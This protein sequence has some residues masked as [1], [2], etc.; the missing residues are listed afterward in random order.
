MPGGAGRFG[1]GGM[2]GGQF[3]FASYG[4]KTEAISLAVYAAGFFILLGLVYRLYKRKLAG[5]SAPLPSKWTILLLLGT[6]LLLRIAIAPWLPGFVGDMNDF[7]NWALEATQGLKTFYANSGSDYP[8]FLIY[9][10]YLI[11]KAATL[12]GMSTFFSTLIKLPSILADVATAYLLYRLAAKW[13]PWLGFLLAAFYVCNPAILINSTFWGQVDSLFTLLIVLIMVCIAEGKTDVAAALLAAAILMKPQGTIFAPVLFFEWIHKRQFK[14]ALTGILIF[15]GTFL[16]IAFPFAIG[17]K[18]LWLV[19]LYRQTIGEYP[20]AS[21]NGYNFFSLIGANLKEKSSPFLLLS[22][23]TWGMLFIVL[24]TLFTWIIYIRGRNAKY[25]ALAALFQIAGVFTFSS[26]MHER[27][28]F[29]AAA[30]AVCA[31]AYLKD[32]RLMWLAVVFSFTGFANTFAVFYGA[33]GRTGSLTN[34]LTM[35]AV[36]LLNIAAV[37]WLAVVMWQLSGKNR[38][39]EQN[40]SLI[41]G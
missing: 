35:D 25:A 12:P 23:G 24:T 29:P 27:Y 5:S 17:K 4:S 36:S 11:G 39:V 9:F 30:L 6:G 40:T 41:I 1:R 8:P 16:L 19:D 13:K 33:T 31:F 37:V 26:S 14:K 28:L 7:R 2:Y 3:G 21:V 32:K 34:T 38:R 18:P 20:Y 15:A 10:L 22:Y